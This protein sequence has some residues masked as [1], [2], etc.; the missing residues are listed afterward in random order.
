MSHIIGISPSPFP[1][2]KYY[3]INNLIFVII[4][5]KII[6]LRKKKNKSKD[7][8]RIINIKMSTEQN[9]KVHFNPK[10]IHKFMSRFTVRRRKWR[11]FFSFNAILHCRCV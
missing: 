2:R 6:N 4:L 5:P 11:F 9:H 3:Y 8:N 1:F 7:E 10:Q